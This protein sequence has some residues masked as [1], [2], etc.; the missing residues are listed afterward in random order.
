MVVGQAVQSRLA[1]LEA[2]EIEIVMS[3]LQDREIPVP[4]PTVAVQL[5]A[6]DEGGGILKGS[7]LSTYF[8]GRLTGHPLLGGRATSSKS[9]LDILDCSLV[10]IDIFLSYRI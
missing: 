3:Q 7:A 6:G 2:R 9:S 4:P 5:I 8:V 10:R 1:P